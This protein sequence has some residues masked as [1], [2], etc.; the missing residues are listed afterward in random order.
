MEKEQQEKLH[1]IPKAAKM[2]GVCRQT[3]YD[4]RDA[5]NIKTVRVGNGWIRV[6][7]SEIER[8]MQK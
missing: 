3:L 6:P 1:T 2:L 4:W 8:I 7:H 5:G